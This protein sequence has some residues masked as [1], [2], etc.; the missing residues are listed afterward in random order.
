[1]KKHNKFGELVII[2]MKLQIV[3]PNRTST[4]PV[5]QLIPLAAK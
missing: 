4:A 1:M 5:S 3:N 2:T